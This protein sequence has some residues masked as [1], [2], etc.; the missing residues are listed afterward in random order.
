MPLLSANLQ[1]RIHR[2]VA[3]GHEAQH[4][5]AEPAALEPGRARLRRQGHHR[6]LNAAHSED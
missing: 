3:V 1:R 6:S 4:Q 5:L 2:R